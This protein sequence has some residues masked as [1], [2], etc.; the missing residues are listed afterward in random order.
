MTARH[1]MVRL[2]GGALI[3]AGFGASLWLRSIMPDAPQDP[4]LLE[5]TLVLASFV[6]TLSGAVL[7]LK[8]ET[9]FGRHAAGRRPAS[10]R[11]G[12]ADQQSAGQ[13]VDDRRILARLLARRSGRGF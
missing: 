13:F 6:L 8:G 3:V 1:V 11:A 4:T 7:A 9:P 5:F 12:P 2:A 10:E